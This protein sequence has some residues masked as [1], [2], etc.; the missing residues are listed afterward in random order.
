MPIVQINLDSVPG[1]YVQ[2]GNTLTIRGNLHIPRLHSSDCSIYLKS[3]ALFQNTSIFHPTTYKLAFPNIS[4]APHTHASQDVS[5][6]F[7]I[8]PDFTELQAIR[9]SHAHHLCDLYLGDIPNSKP[10]IDFELT[11]IG[12]SP[13]FISP[14]TFLSFQLQIEDQYI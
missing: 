11:A 8:Y 13:N 6:V 12:L 7:N 1:A 10:V 9:T 14:P 3:F 4:N 5:M 2:A